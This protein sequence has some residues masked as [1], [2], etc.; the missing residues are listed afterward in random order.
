MR[1]AETS[2]SLFPET[3]TNA[4]N[5]VRPGAELHVLISIY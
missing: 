4:N 3:I 5:R 1:I 2:C